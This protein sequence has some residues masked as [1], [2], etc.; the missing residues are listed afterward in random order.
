MNLVTA[1][2]SH[3]RSAITSSISSLG[4]VSQ[5]QNI[6]LGSTD[7][8]SKETI[9]ENESDSQSDCFE[10]R[11]LSSDAQAKE[12]PKDETDAEKGATDAEKEGISSEKVKIETI[13]TQNA[14]FEEINETNRAKHVREHGGSTNQNVGSEGS[15]K[16]DT[17]SREGKSELDFPD[18][19]SLTGFCS[20]RYH[21]SLHSASSILSSSSRSSLSS[22]S[23]CTSSP[24]VMSNL[25]N[26]PTLAS[27]MCKRARWDA[28]PIPSISSAHTPWTPILKS[29]IIASEMTDADINSVDILICGK[30]KTIFN[31]L[32]L[33]IEH[34]NANKCR[35][36]F[37]CHCQ[38]PDK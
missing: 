16:E 33:F 21:E 15:V 4:T 35:L 26:L 13:S 8:Q 20:K 17:G 31:S 24:S 25:S 7:A 11:I 22:S 12:A 30:C 27:S 1:P 28:P 23:S 38:R 3:Q 9:L 10:E 5:P 37:V 36:R 14:T 34:K 19:A 18:G 29:H 2:K 6:P 32:N